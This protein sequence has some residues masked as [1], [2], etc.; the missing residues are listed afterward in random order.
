LDRR[1]RPS[2]SAS[3]GRVTV[4]VPDAHVAQCALDRDALL[5]T[6]DAIFEAM[7]RLIPLRL[8]LS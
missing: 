6:R 7:A 8:G 4:S 2:T 1:G 3:K 5:L